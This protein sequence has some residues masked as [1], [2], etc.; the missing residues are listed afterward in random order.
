[1]NLDIDEDDLST[2]VSCLLSRQRRL[3][4]GCYDEGQ[5]RHIDEVIK[6]LGGVPPKLAAWLSSC[7]LKEFDKIDE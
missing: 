4:A 7:G 1:M 2:I 3:K 5:Q 6:K